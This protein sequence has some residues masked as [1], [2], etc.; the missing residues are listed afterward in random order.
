[1]IF[2]GSGG[3]SWIRLGLGNQLLH[4]GRV[5]A[6]GLGELQLSHRLSPKRPDLAFNLCHLS[7]PT[8]WNSAYVIDLARPLPQT[9]SGQVQ[10]SANVWYA[11]A[12]IVQILRTMWH[13]RHLV[14]RRCGPSNRRIRRTDSVV[15][16]WHI[17]AR[18]GVPL[19]IRRC[20]NLR[21]R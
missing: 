3:S 17:A 7:L 13:S 11:D 2:D 6:N 8:Q 1:M 20:K 12:S 18:N 21:Y 15:R 4:R 10:T 19:T 9:A 5:T 16:H 14:C